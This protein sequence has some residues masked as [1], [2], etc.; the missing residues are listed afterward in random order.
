M[1]LPLALLR[2]TWNSTPRLLLSSDVGLSSTFDEAKQ[3]AA[4]SYFQAAAWSITMESKLFRI[5]S[6]RGRLAN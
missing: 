2:R 6:L 5:S 1:P 3:M 4:K